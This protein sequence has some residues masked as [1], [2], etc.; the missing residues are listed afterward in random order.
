MPAPENKSEEGK[1]KFQLNADAPALKDDDPNCVCHEARREYDLGH[2]QKSLDLY[3]KYVVQL[4][5]EEGPK[6]FDVGSMLQNIG[7]C[8]HELSRESEAEAAY[9]RAVNIL[10][11]TKVQHP[12]DYG[13]A[14]TCLGGH[15]RDQDNDEKAIA[16]VT[17]GINVLE[18]IPSEGRRLSHSLYCLGY[19]HVKM[20]AP[21]KALPLYERALSIREKLNVR[22]EE[23]AKIMTALGKIYAENKAFAKAESLFEQRMAI[24]KSIFKPNTSQM[25][26]ATHDLAFIYKTE[27]KNDKEIAAYEQYFADAK[28]ASCADDPIALGV[29]REAG[30]RLLDQNQYVKAAPYYDQILSTEKDG[31][32][33]ATDLDNYAV[34]LFKTAQYDKAEA[35]C[36]K[37]IV[38]ITADRNIDHIKLK[39]AYQ[40][41]AKLLR[42]TNREKQAE[43]LDRLARN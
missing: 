38:V 34:I 1:S 37:I 35:I 5:K 21:Q 10:R 3:Q 14:L 9:T 17:E 12:G 20:K 39:S 41:Y 8:D 30:D 29:Y 24:I 40:N 18:P 27:N 32:N 2:W 25:A 6:G 23:T 42:V 31:K 7:N 16:T 36:K 15:Y 26:E 33:Y 11:E 19:I 13:E 28:A 43:E 22:D 4:E